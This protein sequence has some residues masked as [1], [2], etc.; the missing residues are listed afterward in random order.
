VK[1]T[2]PSEEAMES[3]ISA[4]F[5]DQNDGAIMSGYFLVVKGKRMEDFDREVTRYMVTFPGHM[6][7]DQALGLAHYGV[8]DVES[9]FSDD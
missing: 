7:Y 9:G 6:E 5:A 1:A 2:N 4:Y 8:R 3:A